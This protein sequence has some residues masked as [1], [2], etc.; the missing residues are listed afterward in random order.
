MRFA[1]C[2]SVEVRKGGYGRL[3][4]GLASTEATV[5]SASRRPSAD[6][7]ATASSSTSRDVFLTLADPSSAKSLPVAT[8]SLSMVASA[9]SKEV[10][11]SPTVKVPVSPQYEALTKAIRSRSRSTMILVAGDWTRPAESPWR[12]LRHSTGD[13]SYP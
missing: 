9:A 2:C 11:S 1:S 13:T 7:V 8:R 12:T 4:Y 3:V 10:G 5:K 6:P